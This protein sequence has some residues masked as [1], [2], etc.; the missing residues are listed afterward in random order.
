MQNAINSVKA[1]SSLFTASKDHGIPYTTLY[2]KVKGIR[3][4]DARPGPPT[5]LSIDEENEIVSWIF[6]MSKMGFP[7]SKDHLLDTVQMIVKS[8]KR[9]TPFTNGRP[10][11]HWYS[12]FLRRH[13]GLSLRMGQNLTS[14]RAA[15]TEEK[16]RNWFD[17][18]GKYLSSEGLKEISPERIFNMDESGFLL[19]PKTE[20]YLVRRGQKAVYNVCKS[21]KECYTALMGGNAAGQLLPTMIVFKNQRISSDISRKFPQDFVI[22]KNESGWMTSEIFHLYITNHFYNWC[23]N[24]NIAFPVV[25]Y[26]D[27]HKSHITKNLSDFCIDKKIVLVALLPNAT[28]ILQPMDLGF[29]HPLKDRYKKAI[30][31]WRLDNNGAVLNKVFFPSVLKNAIDALDVKNN[32]ISAFERCGL[33][34]FSVNSINFSKLLEIKGDLHNKNPQNEDNMI[35]QSVDC[36]KF[37]DLLE[38]KLDPKIVASFKNNLSKEWLGPLEYKELFNLWFKERNN[39]IPNA[40]T[41]NILDSEKDSIPEDCTVVEEMIVDDDGSL[42]PTTEPIYNDDN[43][44]TPIEELV[45]NDNGAISPTEVLIQNTESNFTPTKELNQNDCGAAMPTEDL[46]QNASIIIDDGSLVPTKLS[47]NCVMNEPL[48]DDPSNNASFK[49]L[50]FIKNDN[51]TS[52]ILDETLSTNECEEFAMGPEI[53]NNN[54]LAKEVFFFLNYMITYN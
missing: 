9:E 41:D 49:N 32:L 52:I 24:N 13:P 42:I 28:S 1:G 22:G 8:Q 20:K 19:T 30:R 48:F 54:C 46:I 44:F 51:E 36:E 2:E 34:P 45:E 18:V 10:S 50:V 33:Y 43:R 40:A 25:L 16:L 6:K 12:S 35:L 14:A 53:S 26:V 23:L 38:S 17:T 15:V 37:L 31:N 11:K 5:I 47:P 29:F 7:I 4:L 27:G 21:D 3:S 39:V